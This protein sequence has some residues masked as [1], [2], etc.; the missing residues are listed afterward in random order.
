MDS[1]DFKVIT[2]LVLNGRMTWAELASCLDL[3]S[4]ATA[5]RVHRLKEQGV[6]TG[7]TALIAPEAVGCG[8]TAFVAVTLERPEHRAPY[9]QRIAQMR[10][11]QECHHIAGEDDYLLKV[12]CRGTRDLERVVSDEIKS[13]PG[14]A[15]TRTTIVMSTYKETPVPPMFSEHVV[16]VSSRR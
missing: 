16:D 4:P 2:E 5:E 8:L 10:E 9:L 12:R 6:I 15:K 13:I 7:F 14:V 11:V 3:S 1:I